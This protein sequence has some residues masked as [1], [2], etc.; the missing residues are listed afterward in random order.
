MTPPYT[1]RQVIENDIS[2]ILNSFY[3]QSREQW[4]QYID[5][6]LRG[7]RVTLI[8]TINDQVIGYT[9]LVWKS[10][11]EPFEGQGIPEINN[12][13]VLDAFTKMGVG[14]ALVHAAETIARNVCKP[15]IGIGVAQSSNYAA[16]QRLYPKLGYIPDI[17]GLRST[18]W[19]DIL[20]LTKDLTGDQNIEILQEKRL[21]DWSERLAI[22]PAGRDALIET[23]RAVC[24]QP[25]L[26]KCFEDFFHKATLRGEWHREWSPLPVDPVVKDHLGDRSS[27]FYLLGYMAAL[28]HVEREYIQRGIS[29]DIFYATMNDIL[30]YYLEDTDVH[31]TW[32]FD[33]FPWL[34]RHLTCRIFRLGR[35]QFM[36]APFEWGV[37]AF[38]SRQ[39]GEIILLGDPKVQLRADGYAEGA[40]GKPSGSLTWHARYEERSDGWYGTPIS[41]Y[42]FALQSP[43]FLQKG[44]WE[45][46]L[47]EGDTILEIHIPRG[48]TLST[49][50]CRDSFQSAFGFFAVHF[51][52]QKISASCCHTWF[53]TPQLQKILPATSSIVNFQREFYLFPFPGGPGFLWTFVFGEKYPDP[54][55]APR[56]TSLRRAVLDWLARGDELF[57]LPGVMFHSP[58]TYGAQPYMSRW[59]N[60]ESSI[61][62]PQNL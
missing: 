47:R 30:F 41:P 50:E 37:T 8:A 15:M 7:A 1:I 17:H 11:Y 31:G 2:K 27:L 5:E 32:C 33:H 49:Q 28:P 62:D 9:N 12:M 21:L 23:A 10:D 35:L 60:H 25:A 4:Q 14:T 16:A 24:F 6:N 22:P 48:K 26:R 61:L 59:D 13:H 18:Q 45:L 55:T 44:D 53:F 3:W 58:D 57:D 42:G 20:Y 46:V 56:D 39:T 43:V 19:G 51:P 52:E 40:G 36:L 29:M 38:R 54:A 34:W